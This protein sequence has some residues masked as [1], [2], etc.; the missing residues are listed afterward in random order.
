M[1][2][3]SL[4]M[5]FR[6]TPIRV[7]FVLLILALLM[8]LAGMYGVNKSYH[9][10]GVLKKGLNKMGDDSFETAYYQYNRTLVLTSSNGTVV[11][12][13]VTY[14]IDGTLNLSFISR[15][16]VELVSGNVSYEYTSMAVD[17]PFASLSF[18]AFLLFL[19]GFVLSTIGYIRMIS[20]LRSGS[21]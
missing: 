3:E 21:R 6:Y 7:G 12:N 19:T 20:D 16:N 14:Y 10:K 17:Y 8:A 2:L 4:K 18:I 1:A 11:V 9:E 5:A 13:N 15:P